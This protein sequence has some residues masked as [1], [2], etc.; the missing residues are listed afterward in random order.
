MKKAPK[1]PK[2]ISINRETLH[3]LEKTISPEKLAQ[4]LGGYNASNKRTCACP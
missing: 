3:Q 2:K 4:I 1:T